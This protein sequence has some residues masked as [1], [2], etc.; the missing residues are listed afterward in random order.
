MFENLLREH[1]KK[2]VFTPSEMEVTVKSLTE[3]PFGSPIDK[4]YH[5]YPESGQAVLQLLAKI[6]QIPVENIYFDNGAT[7][8]IDAILRAFCEPIED[9]IIICTP[10]VPLYK[11]LALL[12]GVKVKEVPLSADFQLNIEHIAANIDNFT[13]LIL[14]CSPN[15]PT[16]NSLYYEDL[17]IILNN[18]DGIVVIDETYINYSRQRSFLT[19]LQDYPNLIVI[20]SLSKAWGLAGVRAGMAFANAGIISVLEKI[21]I[22]YS[23]SQSTQELVYQSLCNIDLVNQWTKDTVALRQYFAQQLSALPI[24]AEVYPSDT[25]FLLVRFHENALDVHRFLSEKGMA[26]TLTTIE[27]CLRINVNT[28]ALNAALVNSLKER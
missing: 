3:N 15:N 25:N 17:E 20:Q 18:F 22:P 4:D 19:T 9:N 1:I 28:I 2:I 10:T 26:T 16:G 13:K 8:V 12:Q 23:L 5:H 21:R 27:H 24:V 7:A 6:K 11:Q 14:L